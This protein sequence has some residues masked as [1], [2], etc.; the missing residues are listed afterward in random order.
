[1]GPKLMTIG[2]VTTQ[3]SIERRKELL[4]SQEGGIWRLSFTRAETCGQGGLRSQRGLKR[5]EAGKTYFTM[6]LLSRPLSLAS[7]LAETNGET[8][9]WGSLVAG[10]QFISQDSEQDGEGGLGL[11]VKAGRTQGLTATFLMV[12]SHGLSGH[13]LGNAQDSSSPNIQWAAFSPHLPTVA[14][15]SWSDQST[16]L[17]SSKPSN[18]VHLI[19]N[20][21]KSQNGLWSS[22]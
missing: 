10:S 14:Q 13:I 3:G 20:K 16:L 19:Q 5:E 4:K 9:G 18:I 17:L 6:N 1:M 15:S 8:R 22:L 21:S 11:P 7:P 2:T 12:P